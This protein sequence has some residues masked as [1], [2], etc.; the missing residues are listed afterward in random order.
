ME[1]QHRVAGRGYAYFHLLISWYKDSGLTQRE[2][3]GR[4]SQRLYMVRLY[5]TRHDQRD[6]LSNN[7]T[8]VQSVGPRLKL[9]TGKV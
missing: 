7:L 6:N 8:R 3:T 2:C 4:N 1:A 5:M 9:V